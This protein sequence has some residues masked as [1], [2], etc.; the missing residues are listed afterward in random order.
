[1]ETRFIKE[2]LHRYL[3]DKASPMEV[4]QVDAW[5]SSSHTTNF[6]PTDKER[7]Q[8]QRRILYDVQ[9]Y[10]AYP[11]FFPKKKYFR[12]KLRGWLEKAAWALAISLLVYFM[13][14]YKW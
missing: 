12:K 13:A 14:F 1:M 10:T 9:C 11:L 6:N 4:K 3:L 5:L 2:R 8:L 7:A